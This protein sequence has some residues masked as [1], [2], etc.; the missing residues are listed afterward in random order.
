M[1]GHKTALPLTWPSN[2]SAL[3]ETSGF[4]DIT[5]A[6]FNKYLWYKMILDMPWDGSSLVTGHVPTHPFPEASADLNLTLTQT[7][8]LTQGRVG[9]WPATEQGPL[10]SSVISFHEHHCQLP[11]SSSWLPGCYVVCSIDNDVIYCSSEGPMNV[12]NDDGCYILFNILLPTTTTTTTT[13][14]WKKCIHTGPVTSH[15][16]F[17]KR[18]LLYDVKGIWTCQLSVVWY[19]GDGRI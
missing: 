16:S 4:P 15:N 6:S 12:A 7:L 10:K 18:I 14:C 13:I 2:L 5:Q 3:P 17:L 9:T 1:S 8:D 11:R 19:T